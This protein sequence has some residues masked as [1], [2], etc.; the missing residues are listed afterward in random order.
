MDEVNGDTENDPPI[1]R[2]GCPDSLGVGFIALEIGFKQCGPYTSLKKRSNSRRRG[3]RADYKPLTKAL[4]R[5]VGREFEREQVLMIGCDIR[6]VYGV[7][8]ELSTPL[9]CLSISSRSSS[10]ISTL[11]LDILGNHAKNLRKS[12]FLSDNCQRKDRRRVLDDGIELFWTVITGKSNPNRCLHIIPQRYFMMRKFLTP[13]W[14][15]HRNEPAL[16]SVV[17]PDKKAGS[18]Q[19][20]RVQVVRRLFFQNI[21]KRSGSR[22][23]SMGD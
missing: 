3:K 2:I 11:V 21:E 19:N 17:L 18:R 7:T 23:Q 9:T 5:A 1:L 14:R 12:P 8:D 4:H 15:S 16:N 10:G 6:R 13:C 20:R 22:L